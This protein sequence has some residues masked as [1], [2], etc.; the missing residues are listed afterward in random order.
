MERLCAPPAYGEEAT[1]VCHHYQEDHHHHD[2]P[3]QVC[4]TQYE[5]SCV[6]KYKDTPVVEDVEECNKVYNKSCEYVKSGYGTEIILIYK[7]N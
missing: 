1:E 6:T 7:K 4:Q 5:T 2:H 3:T